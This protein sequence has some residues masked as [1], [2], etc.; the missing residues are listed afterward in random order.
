[1]NDPQQSIERVS[2]N[3]QDKYHTKN[4]IS[5]FLVE[6]FFQQ[7]R[8]I[9]QSLDIGS[10]PDICEVGCGEG[11]LLKNLH[12]IFP[13]AM[14]TA[15]D[16]SNEVIE[17]AGE[18]CQGIPVNF[19]TQDAEDLGDYPDSTF[20]LVI[21][22]EVL[23]HLDHPGKGL[24]QLTRISRRYLLVSVPDEPIWRILNM[25]R[26]KYLRTWGNTP[27]HLNH[28]TRAQFLQFLQ[29]E[30]GYRVVKRVYPF[31][32]QMILLEKLG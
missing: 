31:P 7:F 16:I 26:G 1:M 2:G 9:L 24:K 5:R 13:H 25:T 12:S 19:S 17:T 20:D 10:A 15:C 30:A 32:W 6:H 8:A 22:S 11:E 23:E 4:P 29:G 28:W 21:C 14:L 18:Y 3:Y 27:G